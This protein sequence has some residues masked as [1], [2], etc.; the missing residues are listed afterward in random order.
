M[1]CT[2][3]GKSYK[4]A[5]LIFA[6]ACRTSCLKLQKSSAGVG[7]EKQYSAVSVTSIGPGNKGYPNPLTKHAVQIT[8]K[9]TLQKVVSPIP[10][11]WL[12]VARVGKSLQPCNRTQG[13]LTRDG[14]AKQQRWSWWRTVRHSAAHQTSWPTS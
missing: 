5:D 8:A 7:D 14:I 13:T 11:M 4:Q 2:S 9:L 12:R 1:G 6:G 10:H 3:T